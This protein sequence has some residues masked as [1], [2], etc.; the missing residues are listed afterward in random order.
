MHGLHRVCLAEELLTKW[1]ADDG[2]IRRLNIE[3]LKPFLYMDANWYSGK[4]VDKYKERLGAVMYKAVDI[5]V[6]VTNQL[7]EKTAS[8]NATVYLSSKGCEV[9]L[10]IPQ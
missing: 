5:R 7:G 8:G 6:D 10:P 3:I 1:M 4:I 2:F 9:K